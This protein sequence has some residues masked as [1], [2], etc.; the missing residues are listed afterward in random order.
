MADYWSQSQHDYTDVEKNF[1]CFPP[2]RS[3]H[4]RLIFGEADA[5]RPDW[6]EYWTV[7]KILKPYLPFQK[8]L[9]ICCGFGEIERRLARMKVA[10]RIV[11]TDIA[12]GAVAE[13]EK[14]GLAEGFTNLEYFVADLNQ[15]SL[16]LEEYDLIWAN[17]AL[18]HIE[19]LERVIPML[20]GALKPGGILIS[21]EYVGPNYYQAGPRQ[22]EI[23]NAVRH[24]IPDDLRSVKASSETPPWTNRTLQRLGI[25]PEAEAD[26]MVYGKIWEMRTKEEWINSDPSEGVN[27]SQI[28]PVLRRTFAEMDVRHFNGSILMHALDHQFYNTFDNSNPRHQKLLEMLVQIEASLIAA[29]ELQSDNAHLICRK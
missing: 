7:E 23:I 9:S 8:C 3:R 27:A 16:P 2:M 21:N 10:A 12:P 17:G 4:C 1:Y 18:H 26:T 20:W 11:G 19:H 29:G 15:T 13:A 14:R 5:S 25:L 6:C 24:L 22:Q 28:I